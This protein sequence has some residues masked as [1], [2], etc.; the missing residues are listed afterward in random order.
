M[1]DNTGSDS[2]TEPVSGPLWAARN[3][4]ADAGAGSIH[5]DE[6][7]LL[8]TALGELPAI[9]DFCQIGS[10]VGLGSRRREIQFVVVICLER[11]VEDQDDAEDE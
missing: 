7:A 1:A 10:F 9:K 5:D 6:G 11:A 3:W 2:M 4:S 8:A